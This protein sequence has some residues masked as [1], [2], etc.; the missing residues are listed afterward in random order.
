MPEERE[1][2]GQVFSEEVQALI[3]KLRGEHDQI[4]QRIDVNGQ[5]IDAISASLREVVMRPPP[6]LS[7]GVQ[8]MIALS[9]T[10]SLA[11]FA[12]TLTMMGLLITHVIGGH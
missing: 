2:E 6:D 9:I 11:S 7:K 1:H 5:R 12:S 4:N 3:E 8:S 10:I